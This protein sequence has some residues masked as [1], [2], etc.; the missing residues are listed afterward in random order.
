MDSSVVCRD[1][2]VSDLDIDTVAACGQMML[3][4][5]NRISGL[6][7]TSDNLIW[8]DGNNYKGHGQPQRPRGHVSRV[9]ARDCFRI[10]Q[11]A[12]DNNVKDSG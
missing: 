11:T 3:T 4:L 2:G 6:L 10:Y 9:K 7:P 8:S 12:A 1:S 5:T